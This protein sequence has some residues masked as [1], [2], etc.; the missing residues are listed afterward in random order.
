M[1]ITVDN[2]KVVKTGHSDKGPWELLRVTTP[3]N[4]E[5]TTFDRSVKPLGRNAIIEIGDPKIEGK[6]LSFNKV[7]K[8]IYEGD[9]SAGPISTGNDD[10]SPEKRASIEA[11]KACSLVMGSY[12]QLLAAG[13]NKDTGIPER[14][15]KLW[16][17]SL[18]WCESKIAFVA[19]DSGS[20]A[21]QKPAAPKAEAPKS[22]NGDMKLADVVNVQTLM[23][24]AYLHGDKYTPSWVREQGGAG[25]GLI[26]DEQ[27]VQIAQKIAK[28][29]NWE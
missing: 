2:V 20:A 28:D 27:A 5:F 6:K 15:A 14:L 12:T 22:Q 13:L 24:W 3:D 7:L 11:Q 19:P 21:T 23:R 1:E 8:V 25:E 10:D 18:D 17:R 9:K 4:T 16:E 26:T 29:N